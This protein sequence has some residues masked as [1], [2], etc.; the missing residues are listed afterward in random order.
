MT[1]L[2]ELILILFSSIILGQIFTRLKMPTVI[3]QLLSGILLGPALLNWIKPDNLISLFSQFGIILLMFLAGLESNLELLKKYFKLSFTIATT[4]VI[5]PITFIG[6][7]SY[8]FGMSILE[9]TFIGIVFSA[10]S[11]SI[12]VVVLQE[13]GQL[14]SRAG[15]AILGAAIFD[16]ILAVVVLSLFTAFSHSGENSG[17]TTNIFLNFALEIGYFGFIWLIYRLTPKLMQLTS[18]MTVNHASDIAALS[19]VLML[20]WTADYVGLSDVIGAFFGGL[21]LRQTPQHQKIQRSID[22]IGYAIFIPVFFTNIG[23]AITFASFKQDLVFISVLTILAIISK[24]WAGKYSSK[25]FGF[26]KNEGNIVGAGMIS[27]GE[28]ALIVAQLG[29]SIHLISQDIYSS[30]IVVIIIT[31]ILSPFILNYFIQ[32]NQ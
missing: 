13:Q 9:A 29:Q 30:I 28:V 14:H 19:L 7:A 22:T 25:L 11:V 2:G 18:K 12:S 24:F 27:R 10:T 31:T 8:L 17:P 3:G 26:S 5:L 23:L 15:T 1:F 20:A 32:N 21:A 4:G 6:L 16:D